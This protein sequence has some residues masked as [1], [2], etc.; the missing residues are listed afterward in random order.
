MGLVLLAS[1]VSFIVAFTSIP[2]V[3]KIADAKKLFDLPDERKIHFIPIPSL[4]GVGIFA[5]MMLSVS[6]LV[7]FP[8]TPGLQYF[9][10]AAVI[11][12]FLGLKDDIL[13]ISPMKKFAGQLIAAFLL[14]YPGHFQLTSL[15]GFLGLTA[16]NPVF[17]MLFSYTTILVV[18]N[19]FNLIDGVDGLAG[20]LGLVSTLFFGVVFAIE[21]DFAYAI[22]AFSMAASLLAFLLYNYSPAKVFMG[23]TGSL[24]LGLVN[25][26]LVIRFINTAS[27]PGTVLQFSAAPAI[28]FAALFVPL[29]DTLR[30]TVLRVY[31]GRSPFDPDVNH[32]HHLLMKRGLSH[33]QI[34]GLLGL[35]AMG[36]IAFA[37]LIQSMGINF[38]IAGLFLIGT[39]ISGYCTFMSMPSSKTVKKFSTSPSAR[40]YESTIILKNIPSTPELNN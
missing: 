15:H 18:M 14:V 16:L 21:N 5:A 1:L 22:L 19:A 38:V 27:L 13:L 12:F 9:L 8:E 34:T 37:I 33:M 20:T 23:D 28:G 39:A 3:I 17:S 10:G 26:V 6:T 30:V 25:A 4:G 29:M 7:S 35:M 40:D 32:I 31:Q 2:V 11:I 36:Y 24:L